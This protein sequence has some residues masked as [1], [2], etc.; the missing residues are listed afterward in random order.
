MLKIEDF[1]DDELTGLEGLSSEQLI[2]LERTFDGLVAA[3]GYIA[4]PRNGVPGLAHQSHHL[5]WDSTLM[6]GLAQDERT[7]DRA[8]QVLKERNPEALYFSLQEVNA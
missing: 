7:L 8:E 1:T 6:V 5:G 3:M 2:A 4:V